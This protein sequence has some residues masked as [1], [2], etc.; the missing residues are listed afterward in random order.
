MLARIQSIWS[1]I[2]S[3]LAWRVW[4]AR[5][6]DRL[7]FEKSVYGPWLL[8]RPGDK[9]FEL[10]IAGYGDLIPDFLAR[11]DREYVFLD[12][13]ANTGV[14]GL[15]AATHPQCRRVIAF[16]PVPVTFGTLRTNIVRNAA[17]KI[18]PVRAAVGGGARYVS[19]SYDPSH[20]GMSRIVPKARR[21]NVAAPAIGAPGLERLIG[22]WKGRVIVKI[23]VEGSEAGVLSALFQSGFRA[24]IS[25]ILIEISR[26]RGGQTGTAAVIEC[27]E[28][29]NFVEVARQGDPDH[30][31][32]HYRRKRDTA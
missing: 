32:A 8:A 18:T 15:V 10:S 26:L 24:A 22:G 9:T 28:R 27:L 11:Q 1:D 16:E 23:D 20:S 31:D 5:Q 30:Y 14:F 29:E 13:G 21:R 19:L 6:I 7:S 25:D 17:S 3:A 4:R 12:I 2:T